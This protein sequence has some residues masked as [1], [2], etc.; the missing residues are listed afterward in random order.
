MEGL[1][2][3]IFTL[4]VTVSLVLLPLTDW[5]SFGAFLAEA[6]VGNTVFTLAHAA[7]TTILP[8]A[9]YTL[10]QLYLDGEWW[11]SWPAEASPRQPAS[12]GRCSS[13]SI[14]PSG[15]CWASPSRWRR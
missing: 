13:R 14:R 11:P 2:L 4:S 10:S 3:R 15:T 8:Y 9:L 6:P 12:S 1:F 7:F 5:G